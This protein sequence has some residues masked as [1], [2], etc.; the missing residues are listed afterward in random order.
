[1][2]PSATGFRRGARQELGERSPLKSGVDSG[3]EKVFAWRVGSSLPHP[4]DV[5]IDQPMPLVELGVGVVVAEV[6]LSEAQPVLER[7][8]PL[9]EAVA[10]LAAATNARRAERRW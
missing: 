2:A 1:M 10:T 7:V 4:Y 6:S 3:F 8:K 5:A 9:V